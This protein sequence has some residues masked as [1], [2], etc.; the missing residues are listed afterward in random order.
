MATMPST[1]LTA[2]WLLVSV[3]HGLSLPSLAR[4]AT[5]IPAPLSVPPTDYWEGVDG[6]WNTQALRLGTPVQYSRVIVSTASQETYVIHPKVCEYTTNAT[7]CSKLADS[8]GG[9]YNSNLSTTYETEGIYEIWMEKNLKYEANALY[10]YDS[11]T[12]GYD[13]QSMPTL[14][15][16]IIG[17]ISAD[18]Y[19][20]GLFGLHPKSTNFT[21][22]TQNVPSYMA[23]LYDQ[24]LIPSVSWG[25]TAGAIYS[26]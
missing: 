3:T 16:Q 11:V 6:Q 26:E 15:H 20:Y 8:R 13:G 18:I 17:A 2:I 5:T 14:K 21:N 10:G 22:I 19:Q 23:T 12:L 1:I 9:I 24:K 7:A 25:Y 4:R